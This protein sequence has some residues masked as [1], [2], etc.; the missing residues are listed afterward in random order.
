MEMHLESVST[1]TVTLPGHGPLDFEEGETIHTENSYKFTHSSI[2]E[3]LAASGFTSTRTFT[4]PQSLFAVT[5]AVTLAA[6]T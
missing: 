5:L 4:D 3:L 6:A 2:A 1:Q